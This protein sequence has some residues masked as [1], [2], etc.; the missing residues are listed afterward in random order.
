MSEQICITLKGE[1]LEGA[2]ICL[3]DSAPFDLTKRS[4]SSGVIDICKR[5]SYPPPHHCQILTNTAPL[6]AQLPFYLSPQTRFSY[7]QS[8]RYLLFDTPSLA[9]ADMW[10]SPWVYEGGP[11]PG[12]GE[13]R[14]FGNVYPAAPD[15]W[16]SEFF[17]HS[18]EMHMIPDRLNPAWQYDDNIRFSIAFTA[19]TIPGAPEWTKLQFRDKEIAYNSGPFEQVVDKADFFFDGITYDFFAQPLNFL[20]G[21]FLE[22][23]EFSGPMSRGF[24]YTDAE[25]FNFRLVVRRGISGYKAC[26]PVDVFRAAKFA[27]VTDTESGLV[28][29]P[30]IKLN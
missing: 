3:F 2:K 6:V 22:L 4:Y 18:V 21:R 12:Y 16:A 11:P 30:P 23:P 1:R 24:V 14:Y 26:W 29:G 7:K 19:P 28:V 17:Y 15:K 13:L 25:E 5:L 10:A 27:A 9:M 20:H 8:N